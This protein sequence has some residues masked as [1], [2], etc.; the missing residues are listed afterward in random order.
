ME[1]TFYF[2]SGKELSVFPPP[3]SIQY[4]NHN[5]CRSTRSVIACKF[6]ARP[7]SMYSG[8]TNSVL[9][10]QFWKSEMDTMFNLAPQDP[11]ILF[12][13]YRGGSP[14]SNIKW[15]EREA[16]HSHPSSA[17]L[18]MSGVVPPLLNMTLQPA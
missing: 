8:V 1:T 18:R 16:D 6:I 15:P 12:C 10:A 9:Q 13:G 17:E 11:R 4:T 7:Y 3:G 14:S 5:T 2:V